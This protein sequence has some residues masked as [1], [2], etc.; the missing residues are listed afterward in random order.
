[1][2]G[3]FLAYRFSAPLPDLHSHAQAEFEGHWEQI[4]PTIT[5]EQTSPFDE[6]SLEL[7]QEAYGVQLDWLNPARISSGV[8]YMDEHGSGRPIIYIDENNNVLYFV[9]TD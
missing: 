2:G 7:M 4:S 3:R 1:M 9:L 5:R 6:A 8:M